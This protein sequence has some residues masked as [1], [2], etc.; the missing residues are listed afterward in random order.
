MLGDEVFKREVT[1]AF[2]NMCVQQLLLLLDLSLLLVFTSILAGKCLPCSITIL[3]SLEGFDGGGILSASCCFLQ[4]EV[5][6]RD[7]VT[8]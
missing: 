6:V 8:E 1:L 4:E 7:I 3:S 2:P 5:K